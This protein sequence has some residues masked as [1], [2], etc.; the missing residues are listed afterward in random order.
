MIAH[1]F[2]QVIPWWVWAVL[3]LLAVAAV[4]RFAGLRAAIA[5]GVALVIALA[6][7]RGAQQGYRQARQEA[8]HEAD[9]ILERARA[10]RAGAAGRG[11]DAA[12]LRDDD[13][14]RRD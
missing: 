8:E 12:R 7:R 3:G 11:G 14:F 13:G 2:S 9:R 10:A 1:V 5:A 4:A 6:H